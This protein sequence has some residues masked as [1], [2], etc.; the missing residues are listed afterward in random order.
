[1]IIELVS[2]PPKKE[3]K[4]SS[5]LLK[6]VLVDGPKAAASSP[7]LCVCVAMTG[8]VFDKFESNEQ[9]CV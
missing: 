5:F 8:C 2:K 3:E 6:F 4:E 1:M 9:L 7:S